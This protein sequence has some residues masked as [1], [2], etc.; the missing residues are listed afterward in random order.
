MRDGRHA[1]IVEDEILIGVGM[2]MALSAMGF[3]SFAFAG[4]AYQAVE[5]AKRR[6]PDLV[7]IDVGLLDG[8]GLSA[9][10]E[11]ERQVGRSP[12]VFVTGDAQALAGQPDAVVV[13]KPFTP[14]D[15]ARAYARAQAA[16][17]A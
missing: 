9:A 15:L 4:T 16:M 7:T 1:L 11:I 17:R 2:Q 13:E 8:D 10:R 14:L 6:R 12:I 5:Q 3:D